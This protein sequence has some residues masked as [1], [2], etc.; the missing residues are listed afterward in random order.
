MFSS[1]ISTGAAAGIKTVLHGGANS[2][3]GQHFSFAMPE[4]PMAEYWLGTDPGI[5][6]QEVCPVPGMPMPENGFVVPSDAPGF[7]LEIDESWIS[8]RPR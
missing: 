4:S 8:P 6:L 2:P 7:G 5:P 1:P 3:Y